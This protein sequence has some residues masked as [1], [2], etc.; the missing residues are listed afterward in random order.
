M[1]G[2]GDPEL[3]RFASSPP[4]QQYDAQYGEICTI[5]RC[6]H[7]SPLFFLNQIWASFPAQDSWNPPFHLAK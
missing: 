6:E 3:G 7:Q 4:S 1:V 2:Q 5:S